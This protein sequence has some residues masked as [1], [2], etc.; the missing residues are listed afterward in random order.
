MAMTATQIAPLIDVQKEKARGF[1]SPPVDP[2]V[3]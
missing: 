1:L 3:L 2:S